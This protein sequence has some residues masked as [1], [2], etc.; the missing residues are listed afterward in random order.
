MTEIY[1]DLKLL[2]LE[3]V[4]SLFVGE[5]NIVDTIDDLSGRID[6]LSGRVGD[7]SGGGSGISGDFVTRPEFNELSGGVYDLSETYYG[8]QSNNNSAIYGNNAGTNGGFNTYIG[9]NSGANATGS[10]NIGLG[11]SSAINL[12]G[13]N[14]IAIGFQSLR[15]TDLSSFP[16]IEATDSVFIGKDAGSSGSLL[17]E[18]DVFQL[19]NSQTNYLMTGDFVNSNIAIGLNRL[20]SSSYKLEVGGDISSDD[21]YGNNL[22]LQND[23][24]ISGNVTANEF[25][26]ESDSNLKKNITHLNNGL[27]IINRFR[28]V[29][30]NWKD[31]NKGTYREVGF[32]A[33]EVEN[34][35]PSLV[36][37]TNNIK[38]VAY[39]KIVSILTSA[40]QEQQ[41]IINTQNKM[42]QKQNNTI[43][44]MK[45]RIG[46]IEKMLINMLGHP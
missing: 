42:I 36:R 38:H 24:S 3:I 44:V 19:Q 40:V 23:A 39:S 4:G 45:I 26:S 30:Y 11:Y 8:N 7:L 41:E 22:F 5:N 31:E 37:E 29:Y 35:V 18:N 27:D 21:I 13:D 12:S 17:R 28:P 14:N 9:V 6:D 25:L 32:I 43:D 34:V 1:R 46:D 33:Q 15:S 10:S 2:N 16:Y 20:P